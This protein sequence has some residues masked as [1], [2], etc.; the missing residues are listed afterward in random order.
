MTGVGFY[1]GGKMVSA[2]PSVQTGSGVF[3]STRLANTVGSF[4]GVKR[5]EHDGDYLHPSSVHI[6][7]GGSARSPPSPTLLGGEQF[8]EF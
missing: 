8:N 2:L 4:P 1:A 5:Q 3:P 6:K 7:N